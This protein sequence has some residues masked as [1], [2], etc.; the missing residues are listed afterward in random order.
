MK[1]TILVID[2]FASVRL[3]HMG[4]LN[5]KGFT[6]VGAESGEAAL[7]ALEAG[8]VDLVL[9]DMVMPGMGGEE[10]ISRLAGDPRHAQLPVLV[11]TSEDA[12]ARRVFATA[13][14]P[15]G[16][17]SKPVMPAALLQ[18][19]QRLISGSVTPA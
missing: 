4:F 15:V 7:A 9:L 19:A 1:P 3:Y 6:C 2:D 13:R 11:I 17:L 10:F 5:R 18:E 16:I 8:P 14:R 12:D